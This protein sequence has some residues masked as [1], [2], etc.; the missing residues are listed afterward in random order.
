MAEE[1]DNQ[2]VEQQDDYTE[3]LLIRLKT[4]PQS[5]PVPLAGVKVGRLIALFPTGMY[6]ETGGTLWTCKCACGGFVNVPY[7]ALVMKEIRSCGCDKKEVVRRG[8]DGDMSG[9][10][11]GMIHI[12]RP[13]Q[14]EVYTKYICRCECGQ[15]LEM[16]AEELTT[17]KAISCGCLEKSLVGDIDLVRCAHHP[18]RSSW[19]YLRTKEGVCEEWLTYEN[20]YNWAYLHGWQPGLVLCQ[21]R[22]S[23]GYDPD[24][25]YWGTRG[26]LAKNRSRR[27]T[28][29]EIVADGFGRLVR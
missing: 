9:L 25:C 16:T 28:R 11:K 3:G 27:R 18:L 20:F 2:Q 5:E 24:N 7:N 1:V 23:D 4:P 17:H 12:L 10:W 19:A 14:P 6:S 22:S 8:C 13:V 21:E 29:R 26:D 15:M